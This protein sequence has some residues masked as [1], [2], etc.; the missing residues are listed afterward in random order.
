M[1]RRDRG[2]FAPPTY[3]KTILAADRQVTQ[4]KSLALVT[5]SVTTVRVRIR[6]PLLESLTSLRFRL[7]LTSELS[8][9]LGLLARLGAAGR[10]RGIFRSTVSSILLRNFDLLVYLLRQ[11][12]ALGVLFLIL[13]GK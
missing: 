1:D 2:F 12:H 9:V 3:R 7:W 11:R 6:I 13:L 4:M 8:E 5:V 10:S